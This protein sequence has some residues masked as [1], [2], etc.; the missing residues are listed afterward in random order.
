MTED[1]HEISDDE[2]YERYEKLGV[3]AQP[4]EVFP[5]VKE[6]LVEAKKIE[7]ILQKELRDQ[8]VALDVG[9]GGSA[10]LFGLLKTLRASRVISLDVKTSNIVK[11]RLK[12]REKGIPDEFYDHVRQDAR[13]LG[14]ETG[15]LDLVCSVLTAHEISSHEREY[16]DKAL[17]VLEL[18]RVCSVERY[19][20]IVDTAKD[21]HG[22]WKHRSEAVN[23]GHVSFITGEDLWGF[24]RTVFP[25]NQVLVRNF[26]SKGGTDFFIIVMR[27]LSAEDVSEYAAISN[28][29]SEVQRRMLVA[30]RAYSRAIERA[31][32]DKA[33]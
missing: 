20:V 24:M 27:K 16:E 30:Y 21:F 18:D 32:Q 33:V 4:E 28:K 5:W 19:V 6:L 29:M 23:K 8:L 9:T 13:V 11:S 14:V 25:Q 7:A 22:V 3:Y 12:L 10:S 26:R 15:S 17:S 2:M 31:S 1:L